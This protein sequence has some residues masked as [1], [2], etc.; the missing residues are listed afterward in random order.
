V[1][2]QITTAADKHTHTH[3]HIGDDRREFINM[4]D[5]K[6]TSKQTNS[7]IVAAAVVMI[8]IIATKTGASATPACPPPNVQKHV[9]KHTSPVHETIN[10]CYFHNGTLLIYLLLLQT[11]C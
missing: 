9:T 5:R 1:Y 6:Q 8:T 3:A 2:L 7:V 11:T 4:R 10:T